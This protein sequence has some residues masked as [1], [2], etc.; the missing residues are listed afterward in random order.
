VPGLS[1]IHE[2]YGSIRVMPLAMAVGQ[3]AGTAAAMM[4]VRNAGAAELPVDQLRARLA[5]SGAFLG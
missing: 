2:M 5:A 1:A 3:A 4:A